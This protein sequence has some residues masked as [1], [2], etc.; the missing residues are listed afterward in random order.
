MTTS[1]EYSYFVSR[2][3]NSDSINSSSCTTQSLLRS[4]M[5]AS[6]LVG[7]CMNDFTTIPV[8]PNTYLLN[9]NVSDSGNRDISD[10]ITS[11]CNDMNRSNNI[12][13]A[14]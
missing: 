10:N 3:K 6:L 8:S 2:S 14:I 1:D 13:L 5:V 4:L 9:V 12:C 7:S 11:T